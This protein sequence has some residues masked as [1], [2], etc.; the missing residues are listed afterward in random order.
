MM[1]MSALLSTLVVYSCLGSIKFLK[2]NA[3]WLQLENHT[4]SDNEQYYPG[5]G[6]NALFAL[7]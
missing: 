5:L 3:A 2:V 4:K 1:Q 7:A 6:K